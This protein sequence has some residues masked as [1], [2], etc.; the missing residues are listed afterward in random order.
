MSDHHSHEHHDHSS[1]EH[2]PQDK[3]I[4]LCFNNVLIFNFRKGSYLIVTFSYLKMAFSNS[5][6]ASIRYAEA[7]AK[8]SF[9]C[10]FW[11]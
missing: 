9:C 3:K 6:N 10:C 4:W 7:V 11:V 2:I 5:I 8:L 1:H